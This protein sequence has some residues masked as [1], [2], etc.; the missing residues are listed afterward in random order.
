MRLPLAAVILLAPDPL[1][2][3]TIGGRLSYP[4]EELPAMTVV[5][6]NPAGETFAVDTKPKQARYRI[7][8]P[9]GRYQVF[10]IALGTGDAS[11]KAPRGAH[12]AY[13]LCARDKARLKAGRCKTGPLED[14]SVTQAR[15][16]ED[17]DI[18]DWCPTR[19]RRRWCC[20]ISS[21]AIPPT[22][23][24][25]RR[26]ARPISPPRPRARTWSASSAR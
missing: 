1:L 15:G 24:R 16:R 20:R 21:R 6:R 8:V 4:S 3:A 12:T 5:A 10:A 17:V 14:V 25:R 19:S 22:S 23:I 26:R 2:A 18:D 9:E 13:S 11:G 7:E